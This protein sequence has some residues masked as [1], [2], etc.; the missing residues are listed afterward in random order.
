MAAASNTLSAPSNRGTSP[1]TTAPAGGGATTTLV[2][3][4]TAITAS[5]PMITRSNGRCPRRSCTSS[6]AIDTIAGDDAA[7]QQ[8]Q[9]E[10]QIQR[11]RATDHLGEVGGDRDEFGLRP[12]AQPHAASRP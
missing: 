10:Q 3:K 4:P 1:P 6:S 11:D 2:R 12:V 5:M 7:D 9:V 8:R